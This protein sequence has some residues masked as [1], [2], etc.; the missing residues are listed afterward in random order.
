M[1]EVEK[2]NYDLRQKINPSINLTKIEQMGSTIKLISS[3]K[4]ELEIKN[5]KQKQEI[6]EFECIFP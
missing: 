1:D 2:E 3:M 4:V 5:R 6:N